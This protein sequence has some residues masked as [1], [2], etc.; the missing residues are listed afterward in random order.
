MKKASILNLISL[1]S[2][3]T[4]QMTVH[5]IRAQSNFLVKES[6]DR[7]LKELKET[8]KILESAITHHHHQTHPHNP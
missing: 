4:Q 3:Q 7:A 6:L 1:A 2:R 5:L 8:E